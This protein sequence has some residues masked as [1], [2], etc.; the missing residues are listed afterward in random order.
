VTV[1]VRERVPLVP[2]TV[3]VYV[4]AEPE[5]D[6]V[7]DPDAPRVTLVGVSVQVR[8]VAGETAADRLT[9]PVNPFTAVTVIVEVPLEPATN[10]TVDGLAATVK[11]FT[12]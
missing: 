11:S 12:E 1:V 8:P 2:V 7:E 5:Q 9:D 6:S 4:P 10:A 3:T